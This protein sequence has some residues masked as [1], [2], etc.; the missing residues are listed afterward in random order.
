MISKNLTAATTRPI[1]L[2]ILKQ[3]SSY[4]YLI[5]KKIKEMSG[6]RMEFSDG[7]LYPVLH[8]LEKDGLIQS[9]WTVSDDTRPRK[10]Y[11]ITEAGKQAL[12]EEKEQWQQVHAVL[13]KLWNV[14]PSTS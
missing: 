12:I 4:G 6:G 2:S 5:I 1:I 9:N 13:E 14:K 10:Y 3:G 7:M 8:R 11:E